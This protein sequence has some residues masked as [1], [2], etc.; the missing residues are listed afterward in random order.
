MNMRQYYQKIKEVEE[1]ILTPEV[2]VMSNETSDGGV[3]GIMNTVKKTVASRMIAEGRA[4]LATEEEAQSFRQE[5]ND[6]Y[7]VSMEALNTAKVQLTVLSDQEMKA[8]KTALKS[9]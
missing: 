6:A 2:V 9:K 7:R 5:T 4:R 3:A 8:I 1:K